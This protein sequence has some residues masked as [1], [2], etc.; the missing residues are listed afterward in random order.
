MLQ[1]MLLA[2]GLFY[3]LY[4][5]KFF[6]IEM[7][8]V[9]TA[10][11]SWKKSGRAFVSFF[12]A[13]SMLSVHYLFF[14]ANNFC[15]KTLHLQALFALIFLQSLLFPIQEKNYI[16]FSFPMYGRLYMVLQYMYY[17]AMS[18]CTATTV[19]AVQWGFCTHIV[20]KACVYIIFWENNFQF[21]SINRFPFSMGSCLICRKREVHLNFFF[22]KK[23]PFFLVNLRCKAK[24]F[25]YLNLGSSIVLELLAHQRFIGE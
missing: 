15:S 13:K 8:Y 9:V 14:V 20:Q 1:L 4:L 19:A 16:F 3:S 12:Q 11:N 5:N 6:L 21:Y 22:F 2:L 24:K 7:F 23:F 17:I 10:S 18:T 25:F